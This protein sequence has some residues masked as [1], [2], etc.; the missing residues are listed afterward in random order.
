MLVYCF[1]LIPVGHFRGP[2][3]CTKHYWRYLYSCDHPDSV[4]CTIRAA[5][6]RLQ[7]MSAIR[8]VVCKCLFT[9]MSVYLQSAYFSVNLPVTHSV[10]P[11]FLPPFRPPA[12]LSVCVYAFVYVIIIIFSPTLPSNAPLVP[13]SSGQMFSSCSSISNEIQS[14]AFHFYTSHSSPTKSH[15]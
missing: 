13:L 15:L 9:Y 6:S 10:L 3:T 12:Y 2:C 11:P 7:C 8:P 5:N 4:F 1:G 14:L